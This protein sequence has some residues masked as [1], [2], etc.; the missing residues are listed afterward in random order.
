MADL[1]TL[2]SKFLTVLYSTGTGDLVVSPGTRIASVATGQV[3]ASGGVSTA[4]AWSASPTL[5]SMSLGNGPASAGL[6]RLA[7]ACGISWTSGAGYVSMRSVV[8]AISFS[9]G[10]F[11]PISYE[12]FTASDVG[13]TIAAGGLVTA[14]GSV[15]TPL[16][17]LPN[18]GAAP[19]S[20]TLTLVGG[21]KT[22]A[23]TAATTTALI[24]FQRITAGGTIGMSTTYTKVAGTSFTLTADNVLDTS[25]YAWWIVEVH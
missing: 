14:S 13:L 21:T 4:P 12:F 11:Y 16:V 20:G 17:N 18:T 3:L 24:F 5:T 8:G 23:T 15:M 19:T 1:T 25:T 6:L 2:L 9:G 10:S 22:V 7:D